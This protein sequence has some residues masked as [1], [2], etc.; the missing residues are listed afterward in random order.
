MTPC[1]TVS[2]LCAVLFGLV[3]L[4]ASMPAK[5][6]PHV[7]I[8]AKAE[9]LFGPKGLITG[10]RH[11]WKFDDMYSAFIIQGIGNPGEALSKEQ[12][13][14]LAKTNVESLSEFK[15]FTVV[16][17]AGK[18]TVFGDPIDYWNEQGADKA[19][20]LHFTLPLKEPMTGAKLLILL[21]Y[22]PTYFV[23][24]SLDD[25]EPVTLT[26]PP[27]GCSTSISKPKDLDPG[28]KQKLS[29]SFFTNLSPGTDFGLKLAARAIVACP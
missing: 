13:A 16:K 1:S 9:I 11:S 26:S 5:A 24:F 21:V 10:V 3:A 29:E 20:T 4:C 17:V 27:N 12:L 28:D 6:H 18:P 14:P 22:D 2:R 15:Y 7:F 23:A 8:T 25:K 19:I